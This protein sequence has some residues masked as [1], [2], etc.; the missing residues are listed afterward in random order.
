MKHKAKKVKAGEYVY[1]GYRI[2]FFDYK[3]LGDP[4]CNQVQWNI[5]LPGEENWTKYDSS[6]K[7][8]KQTIDR[9]IGKN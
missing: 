5:Y 4:D 7:G 1:R 2:E 9:L 6:L 3:S 8:A